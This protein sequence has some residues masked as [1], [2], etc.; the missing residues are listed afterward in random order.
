MASPELKRIRAILD[1][2]FPI[3]AG[4]RTLSVRSDPGGPQI[5][6]GLTVDTTGVWAHLELSGGEETIDGFI[7]LASGDQGINVDRLEVF[8]RAWADAVGE[9][10]E[11]GDPEALATLAITSLSQWKILR[12]PRLRTREDLRRALLSGD[13][14]GS[15]LPLPAA[16]DAKGRT[17]I[18]AARE[19]LAEVLPI[20]AGPATLQAALYGDEDQWK[21]AVFEKRG[22]GAS[23]TLQLILWE[24]TAAD[25]RSLRDIRE[26]E[27]FLIPIDGYEEPDRIEPFLRG[28]AAAL[29]EVF[30]QASIE[31]LE[32]RMPHELVDSRVLGLKRARTAEDFKAALLMPSR[33]GKILRGG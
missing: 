12:R 1:Q 3:H 5:P 26:Q 4:R 23:V 28:L 21:R 8:L 31:A 11:N 18:E 24:I 6:Q 13:A 27:V 25:E 22:V 19:V 15:F 10:L 9:V 32:T 29:L 30:E 16:R 14:L 17:A 20:T 7:C 33:L 2:L